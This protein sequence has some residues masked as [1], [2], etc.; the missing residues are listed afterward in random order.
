MIR[1]VKIP[2][3]WR[4]KYLPTPVWEPWMIQKSR[5]HTRELMKKLKF[6]S[7]LILPSYRKCKVRR[8]FVKRSKFTYTW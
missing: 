3:N 6:P 1:K 7:E 8:E 4:K 2:D 5:R